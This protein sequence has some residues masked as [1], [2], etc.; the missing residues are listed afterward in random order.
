MLAEK[1]VPV[2][3]WA[4]GFAFL[5][6]FC[7][8]RAWG[9]HLAF[10]FLGWGRYELEGI[11]QGFRPPSLPAVVQVRVAGEV[12]LS[13]RGYRVVAE[14]IGPGGQPLRY[15]ALLYLPR[16]LEW[17]PEYGQYL[18]IDSKFQSPQNPPAS[19][20]D[21]VSYLRRRRIAWVSFVYSGDAIRPI[22][23][24]PDSLWRTIHSLRRSIRATFRESLSHEDASVMEGL[25]I[26]APSDFPPPLRE[27]FARA[28][29]AH[30]L[31]ASG[32]HV[33]IVAWFL[34]LLLSRLGVPGRWRRGCLIGGVWFYALLAALQ[35]PIVRAAVMGT[36]FVMAPA[37]RRETDGL[38]ALG[39]AALLWL[40]YA[41]GAFWEIGFRL[42][43]TAVLGILLFAAPLRQAIQK[44]G[45]KWAGKGY[46]SWIVRKLSWSLAITL[47]AQIGLLPIQA[48]SFGYLSFWSP[49][50]NLA[51]APILPF[52]LGL[53]FFHWLSQGMGSGLL[54]GGI[55]W[56][57]QVARLFGEV[58]DFTLRFA[59]FPETWLILF[60]G[61]L[62]LATP[63][64]RMEEVEK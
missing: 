33:G 18:L 9:W 5:L 10:L 40:L 34:H 37:L 28:G 30:V 1:Q 31:T 61:L 13:P 26:G 47:S 11:G 43:F 52:L 51:I 16:S 14:P 55:G 57:K 63:E 41:P 59:P 58:G 56:L 38:C 64:P 48:Y 23:P 50:A 3:V 32:L 60:Y 25:L 17:L 35:P 62:L 53:G 44:V 7:L 6:L 24:P 49:I 22:R 8:K 46:G 29:I 54:T 12:Q 2:N 36:I 45:L 21:W 27:A 42:S 4:F 20:F 15:Y 39:W 19:R